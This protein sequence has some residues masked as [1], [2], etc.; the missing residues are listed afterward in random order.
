[1]ISTNF[2]FSKTTIED[3]ED[4]LDMLE[5]KECEKS[6]NKGKP[7]SQFTKNNMKTHFKNVLKY[8]G[9]DKEAEIIHCKNLKGS[10][11]PEDIL[12]K[13]EVLEIIDH[14]ACLRDKALFGLLYESGC[15]VGEILSMK[16]KNV[17][18]L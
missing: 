13:E 14:A 17:E 6:L 11:L 1:M 8:I 18:F 4:F 5:A 9:K 10:K 12:T 16:V 7:L 2:E 15:R 3:V